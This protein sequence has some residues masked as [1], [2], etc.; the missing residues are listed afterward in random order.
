M[1][2]S[3][4]SPAAASYRALA[5]LWERFF[6]GHE[7]RFSVYVHAPPGVAINVDSVDSPFYGRQIPSQVGTCWHGI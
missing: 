7:N 4:S 1:S 5:P 3:C 6:R 2:L